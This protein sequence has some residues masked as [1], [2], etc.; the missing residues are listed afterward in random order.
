MGKLGKILLS[1]LL[2]VGMTLLFSC[3]SD[4]DG[5][6]SD[7][8]AGDPNDPDF[9]FISSLVDAEMLSVNMIFID[10]AMALLDSIP[11][12]GKI[13]KPA[14]QNQD[15]EQIIITSYTF[16]NFWHIFELS[17]SGI[18]GAE[19]GVDSV[20]LA[21]IDSIRFEGVSGPMQYPDSLLTTI[22]KLRHH[23]EA[24]AYAPE[25]QLGITD[26]GW[27]DLAGE[28]MGDF[29]ING[30]TSDSLYAD[31]DD[32]SMT[33]DLNMTMNQ[34]IDDLLIDS[35]VQNEDVCPGSGSAGLVMT[36]DLEMATVNVEPPESFLLQGQWTVDFVFHSDRTVTIT[37]T[38]G[39]SQWIVTEDCGG[40]QPPVKLNWPEAMKAIY[41]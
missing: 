13:A 20:F 21:G 9:L 24:D 3:G 40:D 18:G 35:M 8:P 11:E 7:L 16:E 2:A 19:E 31:V 30:G 6:S 36:I 5:T 41:K 28:F 37:Y 34:S 22:M 39:Q 1:V 33:I 25:G 12:V 23:F 38:D 14:A 4:D 15:F 29:T 27:L 17:V 10:L 32:T 26:H